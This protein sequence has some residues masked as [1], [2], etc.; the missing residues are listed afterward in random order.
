MQSVIR[1]DTAMAHLELLAYIRVMGLLLSSKDSAA[2]LDNVMNILCTLPLWHTIPRELPHR[3]D[4]VT[5]MDASRQLVSNVRS[6]NIPHLCLISVMLKDCVLRS[7][8]LGIQRP[9]D[10]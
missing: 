7:L 8:Q 9:L 4:E 6:L 10:S 1:N 5:N 3:G 2:L